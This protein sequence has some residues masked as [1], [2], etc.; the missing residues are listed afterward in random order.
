MKSILILIAG[1]LPLAVLTAGAFREL[2]A[3]PE[4]MPA[5]EA[6]DQGKPVAEL[7]RRSRDKS[8]AARDPAKALFEAEL[9][10]A[11]PLA[12]LAT[13]GRESPLL[14][15]SRA[16]TEWLRL[17]EMIAAGAKR[18]NSPAEISPMICGGRPSDL[19]NWPTSIALR[20]AV[21]IGN[22]A[23]TSVSGEGSG[24]PGRVAQSRIRAEAL[25]E[26][27]GRRFT[28]N[29][30]RLASPFAATCCRTTQRHWRPATWKK[31][32]FLHAGP[33]FAKRRPRLPHPGSRRRTRAASEILAGVHRPLGP[34][35]D[36]GHAFRRSALEAFAHD[37]RDA[38]TAIDSAQQ[39]R[40]V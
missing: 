39:S 29:R 18:N 4:H 2:A 32:G 6:D 35:H 19:R 11:E 8:R 28:T 36:K 31:S 16:W 37:L 38:E 27:A 9:F 26:Q 21:R 25:V 40:P 20:W 17:Q 30:I 7:A 5:G 10:A 23:I 1:C 13:V 33:S 24:G 14:G 34:R 15:V 22:C 12:A 3:T